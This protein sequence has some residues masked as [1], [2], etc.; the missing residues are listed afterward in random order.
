MPITR[1][2]ETG[3]PEN[4]Y[5]VKEARKYTSSSRIISVQADIADRCIELLNLEPGK[6]KFVLDVGCGSGLSGAA[7]ERAGHEW[8]GCDVSRDMLRIASE[9][10]AAAAGGGDDDD[11]LVQHDMGLGLP[12]RDG[13]FDGAISVSAL[14]WL[15]YDNDSRQSATKRLGRFFA[16]LYRCL[17]SGSRAA[18]QFYPESDAQATL[19]ASAAARAGFAGGVVVDYP[20]ST[21]ARKHY[22]CLSMDRH[23]ARPAAEEPRRARGGVVVAGGGERAPKRRKTGKKPAKDRAWVLRKKEYQRGQGRDVKDDSRYTGR[24]RKDRF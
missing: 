23:A 10:E 22:L 20:N 1:P 11:D 8:V 6:K 21:K 15:C 5:D 19:I 13:T 3:P 16:S 7:L 2:E 12:F 14:Q 17:K 4:F 24:K 18:L 9:R